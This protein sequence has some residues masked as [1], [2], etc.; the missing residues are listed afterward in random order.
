MCTYQ[1]LKFGPVTVLISYLSSVRN[2]KFHVEEIKGAQRNNLEF[3]KRHSK[4]PKIPSLLV[5]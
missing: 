5:V 1:M 2:T 3:Q 4:S